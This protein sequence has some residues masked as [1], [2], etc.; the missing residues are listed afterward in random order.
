MQ[1]DAALHRLE[2]L[3]RVVAD[4]L[5]EHQLDVLHVLDPCG[6]VTADD[7]EIGLLPSRDAPDPCVAAEVSRAAA[8]FKK[9]SPKPKPKS[10][11]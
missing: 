5:L 3:R 9:K 7:D 1:P 4:S 2:D 8:A 6:R 11:N 10:K